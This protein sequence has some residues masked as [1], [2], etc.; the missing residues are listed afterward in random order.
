VTIT[1]N[2][3]NDLPTAVDDSYATD[4]GT[5]LN[6]AAPGVLTNDSDPE[7]DPLTAVLDT[8]PSNGTLTL[9]GDGSFGYTPDANFNGTDSFTYHASDGT[10]DS[11]V[12]T[13]TIT[14]NSNAPP[15]LSFLPSDDA[16]VYSNDLSG[17]YGSSATLELREH[18][19]QMVHS[20]LKF[21]INGIGGAVTSVKLR[22]YSN[23][24]SNSIVQIYA[25][26]NDY[27]NTSDPWVEG[28]LT[29]DNA[30]QI[31]GNPIAS[32]DS[33]ASGTWIEFDLTQ[34]VV[35]NGVYSFAL[36]NT[37]PNWVIVNSKEAIDN[38]PELIITV[39]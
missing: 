37:S 8:G 30:P 5:T 32:L 9:N 34:A 19:K 36:L 13:V 27:L 1:V 10:A 33:V 39:Q 14:V 29:W 18:K 20:F 3:V 7:N 26:S 23:V 38:Q 17:N 22:L 11:N 31:S 35:G 12:A 24:G 15:T 6:E 16:S 2:A 21:H 4:E 25:V 28:G